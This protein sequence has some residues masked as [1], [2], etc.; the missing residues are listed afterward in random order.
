MLLLARLST[1]L[2]RGEVHRVSR[3]VVLNTA[4][5][6][7]RSARVEVVFLFHSSFVELVVDVDSRP[8]QYIQ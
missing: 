5:E 4:I 7:K 6:S 3:T 2:G 8:D 1:L